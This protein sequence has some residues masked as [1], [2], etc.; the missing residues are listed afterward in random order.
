MIRRGGFPYRHWKGENVGPLIILRDEPRYTE[1]PINPFGGSEIVVNFE[2]LTGAIRGRDPPR[3][4]AAT[5]ARKIF[6]CVR[7]C[8][9]YTRAESIL[10]NQYNLK[11]LAQTPKGGTAE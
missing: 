6:V 10:G 11:N 1:D 8:I 2:N 3:G 9:S 4:K 7:Y 5:I